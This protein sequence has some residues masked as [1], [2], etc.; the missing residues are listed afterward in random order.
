MSN[1]VNYGDN[2]FIS[3]VL[4]QVL[5]SCGYC[6]ELSHKLRE[7]LR[8]KVCKIMVCGKKE[9]LSTKF[10]AVPPS[11][12]TDFFIGDEIYTFFEVLWV[13]LDSRSFESSESSVSSDENSLI[14]Y[15]SRPSFL[16]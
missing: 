6:R 13:F 12:F 4:L 10:Y 15:P 11:L 3:G 16:T 7:G 8:D 2:F 14:L 5:H 9:E 1:Y